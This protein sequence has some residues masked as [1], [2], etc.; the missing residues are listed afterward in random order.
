[1]K[2]KRLLSLL[3]LALLLCSL[4]SCTPN[5]TLPDTEPPHETLPNTKP[6]HETLPDTEPSLDKLMNAALLLKPE[7]QTPTEIHILCTRE[8]CDS[9]VVD[10]ENAF[11]NWE[12]ASFERLLELQSRLNVTLVPFVP[13]LREGESFWE[14]AVRYLA[15]T[16][17]EVDLVIGPSSEPIPAMLFPLLSKLS[18]CRDPSGNDFFAYMP[19]DRLAQNEYFVNGRLLSSYHGSAL[20]TLLNHKLAGI[21]VSGPS[22]LRQ[23]VTEGSWTLDT[24]VTLAK[25]KELPIA[26]KEDTLAATLSLAFGCE[27]ED[28]AVTEAIASL[29][30]EGVLLDTDDPFKAFTEE[31]AL[32]VFMPIGTPLGDAFS[33]TTALPLPKKDTAQGAYQTGAPNGF[34]I[35]AVNQKSEKKALSAAAIL[36]LEALSDEDCQHAYFR[37]I[38]ACLCLCESRKIWEETEKVCKEGCIFRKIALDK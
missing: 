24:L 11:T 7:G 35:I 5:D 8:V 13:E 6:P 28:A 3:L 22:E 19:S 31:R 32:A 17:S 37:D 2:I 12:R 33:F 38:Y 16:D 20:V 30:A 23:S 15:A 18:D 25:S 1:M 36:I 34:D 21:S 4:I 26:C 10:Y 9:L 29:R 14:V 27:Q